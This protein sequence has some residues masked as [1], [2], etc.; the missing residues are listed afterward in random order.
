[1]DLNCSQRNMCLAHKHVNKI[2][3]LK[4]SKDTY[5]KLFHLNPHSLD[6]SVQVYA[7][8]QRYQKAATQ[9]IGKLECRVCEKVFHKAFGLEFH[10]AHEHHPSEIPKKASRVSTV[11]DHRGKESKARGS[12][13]TGKNV[14]KRSK[15]KAKKDWDQALEDAWK[16]DDSDDTDQEVRFSIFLQVDTIKFS[17]MN[18]F[19]RP[20]F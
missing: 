3:G 18:P 7:D 12:R 8:S 17:L 4:V 20:H 14:S 6:A 16:N 11:K 2:N 19:T 10:M 1:M 9:F 5:N 13:A 15:K